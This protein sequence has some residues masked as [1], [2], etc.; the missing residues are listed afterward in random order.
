MKNSVVVFLPKKVSNVDTQITL[1]MKTSCYMKF[2]ES[3]LLKTA[4]GKEIKIKL[5]ENGP[6]EP[7]FTHISI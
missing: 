4:L 2:E 3:Q 7:I 1:I 5:I 6:S